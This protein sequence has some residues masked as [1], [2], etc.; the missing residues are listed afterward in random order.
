L[1]APAL[2]RHSATGTGAIVESRRAMRPK[3]VDGATWL[4]LLP[5]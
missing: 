3:V 2:S 4:L 1:E 5:L